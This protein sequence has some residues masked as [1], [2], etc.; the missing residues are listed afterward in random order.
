VD[1]A[2]RFLAGSELRINDLQ[3]EGRS[4]RTFVW[5][6]DGI[7]FKAR[8]D[9]MPLDDAYILDYKTT[10]VS[11][12]PEGIE[13]LILNMGY[14]I[15]DWLYKR[16]VYM[17]TGK[18]PRFVFLFQE[19][20]A[21]YLCS[22]IELSPQFADMGSRAERGIEIWKKCLASDCWPGYPSRICNVEP[23][24]WAFTQWEAS[25]QGEGI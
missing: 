13:R 8:P 14:E 22:L 4:E 16:G 21:P 12:N 3:A 2:K 20:K 5:V 25:Q 24:V 19:N 15:Q 18:V 1:A 7:W 10:G 6:E 17:L 23:P 11:A 9:W